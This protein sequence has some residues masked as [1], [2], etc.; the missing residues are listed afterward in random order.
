MTKNVQNFRITRRFFLQ[1]ISLTI[2]LAVFLFPQK[3]NAQAKA[4]F[5]GTWAFNETKSVLGDAGGFRR[6]AKQ[7]TVKQEGN[8][9]TV[10]RLR[11]RNG[12]ETTVTSKYTLD[13]K[14]CSNTMSRGGNEIT[15]KSILTWSADG[16]A[17]TIATSMD[18]NGTPVKSSEVWK[19]TDAKTLSILSTGTNREGAETKTTGVYD[20]K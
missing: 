3:V 10:D 8:N 2:L 9:L 18:F 14:E 13:G 5:G 15:S 20:K 16:K 17:L 11:E 1:V 4:N 19:L 12:E 7:L 6:P